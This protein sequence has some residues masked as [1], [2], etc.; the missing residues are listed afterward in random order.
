MCVQRL[1]GE[2]QATLLFRGQPPLDEVEVQ[3]IVAAVDLVAHQR[4]ADVGHMDPDLVLASGVHPDTDDGEGS[5]GATKAVD[6]TETGARPGAVVAHLIADGDAGFV[7]FSKATVDDAGV[8]VG[9]AVDDGE[10]FLGD[11]PGHPQAAQ[12]GGGLL[13]LAEHHHTAGFAVEPVHHLRFGVEAQVQ[14]HATD[15]AGGRVALGG[16][17]HQSCGF[18]HDQQ[19][20]VFMDD[21]QPAHRSSVGPMLGMFLELGSRRSRK[22]EEP[23][24]FRSLIS[25]GFRQ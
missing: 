21:V 6:H 25:D 8:V 3:G 24:R 18:V 5:F 17:T 14:S 2:V 15:Q 4:M 7:V 9:M 22:F 23:N 1:V 16:V 10:V 13:G 19:C 20:G 12:F 11:E